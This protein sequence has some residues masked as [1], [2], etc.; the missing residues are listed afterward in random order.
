MHDMMVAEC[1]MQ[2]Y[3]DKDKYKP[4]DEKYD[5]EW[6]GAPHYHSPWIFFTLYMVFVA[7]LLFQLV[8]AIVLDEFKKMNDNEKLPVNGDMIA[9][10]ND[11]WALL[12]RKA[13]QMIPQYKLLPFLQAVEPPI[14]D[15]NGE[16]TPE[17]HDKKAKEEVFKMNIVVHDVNGVNMVHY[18]DT[19]VAVVRYQYVTQLGEEVGEDL[20]VTMIESPELTAR[21]VDAYPHLTEIEDMNVKD[22]REELS[23]SRLQS[24]YY[25]KQARK[26]M[27]ARKTHLKSEVAKLR[28]LQVKESRGGELIFPKE[29]ERLSATELVEEIKKKGGAAE[30]I[31]LIV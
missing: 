23:A 30:E 25:K 1:D 10:F 16:L 26:R 6:R 20:D 4:G 27:A 21:I 9:N 28:G 19:I 12:D 14:F 5:E 18:V 29:I 11:H 31:G 22:F 8:T 17:Q 3:P 24:A 7:G 13:T 15:P 2:M